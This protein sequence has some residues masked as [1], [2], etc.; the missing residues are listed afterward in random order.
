MIVQKTRNGHE[1]SCDPGDDE[2]FHAC[3]DCS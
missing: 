3:K 1:F 2:W